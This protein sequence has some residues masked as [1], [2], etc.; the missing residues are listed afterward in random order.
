MLSAPD[1]IAKTADLATAEWA[2]PN[3]W[4]SAVFQAKAFAYRL[5]RFAADLRSAAHDA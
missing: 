4:A 2:V 3:R 5:R 1:A